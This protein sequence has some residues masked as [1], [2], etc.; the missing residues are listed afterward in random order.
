MIARASARGRGVIRTALL[1]RRLGAMGAGSSIASPCWLHGERHISIG[2]NVTIWRHARLEAIPTDAGNAPQLI[3]G[4][5]AVIQPYA[6]IAAAQRVEIGRGALFASHVYI[7]DH[8]HDYADPEDPVVSNG[9]VVCA[10]V[11]IGDFAWLGERAVVLKGVTIGE[12]SII[13]AGSIV[14]RDVP[15]LSIA[16]GAPARVIRRY[17]HGLKKWVSAS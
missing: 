17:D 15:P 16:I 5:G 11:S 6:H 10:P 12:R 2:A 14:T 3:I 8:D 7:S 9:R 4:D 1:R 13:G